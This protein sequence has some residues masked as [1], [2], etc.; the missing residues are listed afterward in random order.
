MGKPGRNELC[1]CGSGKKYKGCHLGR[2]KQTRI[3][4]WDVASKV[5]ANMKGQLCLAPDTLRASCSKG[6]VRAHTVARASLRTIA[7]SDRVYAFNLDLMAIAKHQGQT[8]P[9]LFG[10]NAAS[11]FTGF[12]SVHDNQIFAP[13]EKT[14]FSGSAEQCF[15]LGYRALVR[16]LFAKQGAAK[17]IPLLK[18]MDRGRPVQDQIA[19]Q[20]FFEVYSGGTAAGLGALETY[21]AECDRY[22]KEHDF[23]RVRY[24][25]VELGAPPDVMCSAGLF[26]ECDFN[27]RQLQDCWP[28][29]P[30][31]DS[32]WISTVGWPGRGA[33]VFTWLEGHDRACRQFI[34]SLD[35][36]PDIAIQ[37]AVVRLLFEHFENIFLA[38]RWWRSLSDSTR[39]RL[40]QRH[41]VAADPMMPREPTCLIDDGVRAVSWKVTRRVTML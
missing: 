23:S 15:L 20:R 21:K 11:V 26:P 27:G 25:I 13:L 28:S 39:Q 40:L 5:R 37:H 4:L 35:G 14:D 16:E 2:S 34:G 36:L 18:D 1:W 3:P 8:V 10:V 29:D 12:C 38:P 19:M 33:L 24:Y 41:Q 17:S 6:I 30:L 32:L 7:E 9:E 31:P 22:L